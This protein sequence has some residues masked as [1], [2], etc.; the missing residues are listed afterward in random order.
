MNG[1]AASPLKVE[2]E[3]D[4]SAFVIEVRPET[5]EEMAYNEFQQK[6]MVK[7]DRA[8][9]ERKIKDKKKRKREEGA[10][11]AGGVAVLVESK[12]RTRSMARKEEP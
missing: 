11:I 5:A 3:E 1:K 6:R 7:S 9:M 4:N 2:G 10:F 12:R 8:S